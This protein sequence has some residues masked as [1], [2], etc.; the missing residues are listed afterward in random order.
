MLLNSFRLSLLTGNLILNEFPIHPKLW[1]FKFLSKVFYVHIGFFG[2]FWRT[3]FSAQTLGAPL[4]N[5]RSSGDL[6][7]RLR[8]NFLPVNCS[9]PHLVPSFFIDH[10]T[11]P[12]HWYQNYFP[13]IYEDTHILVLIYFCL[14]SQIFSCFFT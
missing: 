10:K 8:I 13:E 11:W 6:G 1:Y 5:G 4:K 3:F 14:I 9:C 12:D 7:N 2:I